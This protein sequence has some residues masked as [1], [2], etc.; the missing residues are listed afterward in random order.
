MSETAHPATAFVTWAMRVGYASRAVLYGTIGVIALLVVA[1]G[2]SAAGLLGSIRRIGHV[3]GAAVYLLGIALGLLGYSIWR[4][5]DSLLNLAGHRTDWKGWIVRGGLFFIAGLYLGIAYYAV[6]VAFL[7]GG[8]TG[9]Q[10][11]GQGGEPGQRQLIADFL[12]TLM[13]SGVGRWFV[14]V[15]GFGTLSFGIYSIQKGATRRFREHMRRTRAL[16]W[17]SPVLGFGLVVRGIVLAVMGGFIIWAG[18]TIDP[19]AAGGYGF[20]LRKIESGDFGDVLLAVAGVGMLAFGGYCLSETVYRVIPRR[21]EV[22]TRE[23]K[24]EITG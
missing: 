4:G 7:G 22:A 14:V 5:S 18:W 15:V 21:A 3:P 8:L 6:D 13:G 11:G 19:R 1:R 12:G 16:E 20:A 9:G 2:G 23:K 24:R 17:L 10:N